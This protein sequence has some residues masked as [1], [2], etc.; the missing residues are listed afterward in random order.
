MAYLKSREGLKIKYKDFRHIFLTGDI[1]IGK[2][3]AVNKSL[4]ILNI[5]PSDFRTYFGPDRAKPDRLLY[6]RSASEPAVY[7]RENA[8]AKFEEGHRVQVYSERFDS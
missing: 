1:Q 8:I 3:T 6:M 5:K 4:E 2:T 7:C